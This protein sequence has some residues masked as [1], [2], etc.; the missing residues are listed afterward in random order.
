MGKISEGR[1]AK[2]KLKIYFFQGIKYISQKERSCFLKIKFLERA[3]EDRL[4]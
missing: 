1:S 2:T 4:Q 3:H